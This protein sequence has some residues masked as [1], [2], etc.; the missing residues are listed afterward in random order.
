[1]IMIY[2]YV[3]EI[4]L[5]GPVACRGGG[6]GGGGAWPLGASLGG[7]NFKGR[8]NFNLAKVAY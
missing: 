4:R 8:V 6:A 2:C 1:M 3:Y 7:A 5:F